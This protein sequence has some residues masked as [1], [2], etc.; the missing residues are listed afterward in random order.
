MYAKKLGYD[1]DS[2]SVV[3]EAFKNVEKVQI[4]DITT[5]SNFEPKKEL[6]EEEVKSLFAVP[7]HNNAY[8]VG[9][10][11]IENYKEKTIK[12]AYMNLVE[13]IGRLFGTSILS[14]PLKY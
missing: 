2:K 13:T 6:K 12:K 14:L 5:I 10:I 9:V 7:V 8:V 4:K 1:F 11:V 3:A